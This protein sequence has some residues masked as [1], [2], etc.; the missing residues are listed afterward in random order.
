MSNIN[1]VSNNPNADISKQAGGLCKITLRNTPHVSD[2]AYCKCPI[3]LLSEIFVTIRTFAETK[4]KKI[5]R[6]IKKL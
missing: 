5:E 3:Q 2:K 6:G 1:R 4:K